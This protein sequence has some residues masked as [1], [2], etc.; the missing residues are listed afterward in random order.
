MPSGVSTCNKFDEA[1]KAAY[2]QAIREG[3]HRR[4][5]AHAAAIDYTTVWRYRQKNPAFALEER[6]AE[7][8]ATALVEDALHKAAT[9]GNTTAIQVWLYNRQPKRWRDRRNA[10]AEKLLAE[11]NQRLS[12]AEAALDHSGTNT[13]NGTTA[14]ASGNFPQSAAPAAESDWSCCL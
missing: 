13:R 10:E 1:T 6:R 3:H 12:Q 5:A 14:K 11:L 4:T 9:E 8:D 2:L 7:R